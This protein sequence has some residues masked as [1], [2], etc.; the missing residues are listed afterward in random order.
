M[1]GNVPEH[2][3]RFELA[4]TDTASAGATYAITVVEAATTHEAIV[5]ISASDAQT[6]WA[7]EPPRWIAD[8]VHGFVKTLQKNHAA[9]A[10]WPARL[11]RWRAEKE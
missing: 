1:T 10:S 6:R 9:D 4:R 8:T 11:V 7:A 2:G 5:T 3:A